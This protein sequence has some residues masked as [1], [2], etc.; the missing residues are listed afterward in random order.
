MVLI[1]NI[2]LVLICSAA[3]RGLAMEQLGTPLLRGR[4]R[5]RNSQYV[6]NN[7]N[8]HFHV[9][10]R[11]P[12]LDTQ[13]FIE[14]D[15]QETSDFQ[16]WADLL[17]NAVGSMTD[18]PMAAPLETKVP[19][20]S[21]F[22]TPVT[23]EPSTTA[24]TLQPTRNPTTR[25]TLAPAPGAT[26]Q[27]TPRPTDAP[28]LVPTNAPSPAPTLQP[29]DSPT[30]I[31]TQLPTSQPTIRPSPSPTTAPTLAP[32]AI[33]TQTPEDCSADNVCN[34]N[35]SVLNPDPDCPTGPPPGAQCNTVTSNFDD[36]DEG[37][38]ITGD[39]Q[40][41]LLDPSYANE[42]GNPGGHIFA[43]DDVQGGVW[44]FRAPPKFHGDFS[45]AYG[46]SLSFDLLQSETSSQFS[47]RDVLIL[48]GGS[49]IWFDTANNPDQ[50]WT[51]YS[52]P[53]VEGVGWSRN[54]NQAATGEDIL[55]VLSSIEDI[56]IRGEFRT[57]DDTGRLDNVVLEVVCAPT[58]APT[59]TPASLFDLFL[60]DTRDD[61]AIR[62]LVNGQI[63]ELDTFSGD[64]GLTVLA[65]A[66]ESTTVEVSWVL[67]NA[68]TGELLI[69]SLDSNNPFTLGGDADGDMLPVSQL[70]MEGRYVLEVT[71]I[72]A[73]GIAGAMLTRTFSVVDSF[74]G[75]TGTN[76]GTE[77]WVVELPNLEELPVEDPGNF[78]IAVI[79]AGARDA[80]VEVIH[81][82][83]QTTETLTVPIGSVQIVEYPRRGVAESGIT[84]QP[85]YRVI[86]DTE[87]VV[88]AFAPLVDV[89][90][91]DAAL[92]LPTAGL[93]TTYR[94]LAYQSPTDNFVGTIYAVV[95]TQDNTQVTVS[96]LNRTLVDSVV[97]N[98]GETLQRLE[99]FDLSGYRI[100]S[101]KPVAVFSGSRCTAAGSSSEYCDILYEQVVPE[102]ALASTY[103]GCPSLSRPIGCTGT[104]CAPGKFSRH[105]S[106]ILFGYFGEVSYM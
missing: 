6:E 32:T 39:A 82:E 38:T 41:G 93:G 71:P 8:L 28:T 26:P 23:T 65:D 51:T 52:L 83:S 47:S 45:A 69:G 5:E 60:V 12:R 27:P 42:G 77:F 101:D 104:S 67:R 15:L 91:N 73:N 84:T 76:K 53:L 34:E 7:S 56:Q 20:Q 88:Y 75:G 100:V 3:S 58:Q 29:T 80:Q 96:A 105:E 31:P 92:A 90:S 16:M 36:G 50:T 81:I 19:T 103:L 21:P 98:A 25:P 85:T 78:G 87:V 99:I 10:H 9:N 4:T 97:L 30:P 68:E 62:P 43:V 54:D 86:S 22:V 14:R 61:S 102:Q 17:Q 49:L 11:Y 63:I 33:P 106:I 89:R 37:W 1:E 95:A 66:D 46:Y 74:L 79:N 24:P 55:N 64:I 13:N 59:L 44:R 18:A 70:L 40:D 72:N 94:V 48:G 57:G 35:C 2:Y